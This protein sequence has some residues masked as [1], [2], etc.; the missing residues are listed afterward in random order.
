MD[1]LREL[2]KTTREPGAVLIRK[3][4]DQFLLTR[5]PGSPGQFKAGNVLHFCRQLFFNPT[6]P[7]N[8]IP[9]FFP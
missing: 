4:V 5:R 7:K 9:H 3:A 2:S 8:V 6:R 1:L